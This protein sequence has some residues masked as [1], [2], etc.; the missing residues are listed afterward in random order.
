MLTTSFPGTSRLR[1]ANELLGHNIRQEPQTLLP[2][3]KNAH[4]PGIVTVPFGQNSQAA[5]LLGTTKRIVQ[6]KIQK[7]GI[8]RKDFYVP[9]I[10]HH[11][12]GS[13][14]PDDGDLLPLRDLGAR[15][16]FTRGI[17]INQKYMEEI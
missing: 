15:G 8:D 10:C 1:E 5:R 12:P 17:I 7:L 6:Y 11:Q 14:F 2:D 9:F 3:I 16:K 4:H 13:P